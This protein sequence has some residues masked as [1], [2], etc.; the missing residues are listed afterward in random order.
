MTTGWRAPTARLHHAPAPGSALSRS[1]GH[2]VRRPTTRVTD[3]G[4][5][6]L[7][8]WLADAAVLAASVHATGAAVPWHVLLLVYGSG[9]AAQSL[10]ITPAVS[11]SPKVPWLL[12][13]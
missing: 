4:T 5:A 13:W 10:N 6:P 2:A 8:N 3:A 9:I 1:P 11:G 12:L 7:A